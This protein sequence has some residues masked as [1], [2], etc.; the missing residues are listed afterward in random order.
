MA[1]HLDRTI[2]EAALA[3]QLADIVKPQQSRHSS[4][5]NASNNPSILDIATIDLYDYLSESV[6]RAAGQPDSARL[7]QLLGL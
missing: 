5:Q 7:R 2:D 4:A 6:A 3:R 1:N